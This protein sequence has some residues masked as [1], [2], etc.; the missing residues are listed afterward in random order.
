MSGGIWHG[1]LLSGGHL[2]GGI[3]PGGIC[4]GGFCPRTNH[5]YIL[6]LLYYCNIVFIYNF[7]FLQLGGKVGIRFDQILRTLR[8]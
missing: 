1:G 2:S 4:P 5:I 6:M 8:V 3:C 7:R